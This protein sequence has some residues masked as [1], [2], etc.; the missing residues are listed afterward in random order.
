METR[1]VSALFH[2]PWAIPVHFLQCGRVHFPDRRLLPLGSA[3]AMR[4]CTWSLMEFGCVGRVKDART[5]SFPDC[6]VTRRLMFFTL[7]VTSVNGFSVVGLRHREERG[8]K[9]NNYNSDLT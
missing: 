3:A 5:Q 1:P 7:P 6:I 4:G 2:V 9:L 8:I